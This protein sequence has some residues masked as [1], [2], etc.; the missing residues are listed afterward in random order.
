MGYFEARK[1]RLKRNDKALREL[2]ENVL[3]ADSE[4]EAYFYYDSKLQDNV[5]F[6]KGD[7]INSVSFHEVPYH[8]SG[9][10]V[11]SHGGIQK[12]GHDICMPFNVEDVLITFKPVTN[13][14]FRHP[15]NRP[16]EYF[17]SKV[18]YLEWNSFYKRFEPNK[19]R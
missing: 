6:F 17:K 7:A 9:C 8:W 18:Q 4:V 5:L 19:D 12:D 16:T 15:H 14:I 13:I 3:K 2:A 10:G 1:E 11:R